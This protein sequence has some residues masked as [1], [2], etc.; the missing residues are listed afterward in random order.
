MKSCPK[1]VFFS[2][3]F[4]PS[5]LGRLVLLCFLLGSIMSFKPAFQVSRSLIAK[6][7]VSCDQFE[8]AER[9]L[10]LCSGNERGVLLDFSAIDIGPRK[11]VEKFVQGGI[12]SVLSDENKAVWLRKVEFLIVATENIYGKN[13][14]EMFDLYHNLGRIA[15]WEFRDF[16]YC[17]LFESEA[18]K[19]S[20]HLKLKYE[21]A[22]ALHWICVYQGLRNVDKTIIAKN[23]ELA[24]E[25][26]KSDK[27]LTK[28]HLVQSLKDLSNELKLSD[29]AIE[30]H[31]LQ[32]DNMPLPKS[33]K[34]LRFFA[35]PKYSIF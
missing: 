23:L 5:I 4:M 35:G 2:S 32:L 1:L 18:Y 29:I 10:L 11:R 31:R 17:E 24:L 12:S 26:V 14:V 13:S 8:L 3:P 15:D 25:V 21:T 16:E 19:I 6:K 28:K 9:F 7:L 27:S 22:D 30:F 20:S 33:S 34:S